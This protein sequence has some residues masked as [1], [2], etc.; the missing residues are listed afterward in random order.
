MT[1]AGMNRH[2]IGADLAQTRDALAG[3]VDAEGGGTASP[4]LGGGIGFSRVP[5][6]VARPESVPA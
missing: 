4:T 3:S 2:A 1:V 6:N 5:R